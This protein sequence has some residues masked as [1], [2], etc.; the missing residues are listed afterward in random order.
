[1]QE[2]YKQYLQTDYIIYVTRKFILLT[3]YHKIP[4]SAK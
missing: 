1:M 2:L 3:F 4:T